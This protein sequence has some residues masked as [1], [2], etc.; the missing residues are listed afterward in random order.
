MSKI[1]SN[2]HKKLPRVAVFDSGLGGVSVLKHLVDMY[3]GVPF[4][5]FADNAHF[6]YGVKNKKTIISYT[7]NI[8]S[9]LKKKGVKIVIF[10][11]NTVSASALQAM[12]KA[13][14]DMIFIG[15]LIPSAEEVVDLVPGNGKVA[16]IATEA[17]INSKW[18]QTHIKKLNRSCK[19]DP[20]SCGLM[21]SLV[22]EGC[23]SGEIAELI[24]KKYLNFV[25]DDKHDA[26]LLACT[27]FSFLTPII[28]RIVPAK[29]KVV[30]PSFVVARYVKKHY[31]DN[32]EYVSLKN[33]KIDLYVTDNLERFRKHILHVFPK[34]RFNIK[35]VNI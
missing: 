28:K 20:K 16:V 3:P 33:A 6:P 8:C 25:C 24:V 23:F 17:T 27:H 34:V 21:V 15:I 2:K 9:F 30:D 29:T 31:L 22:E 13:E 10:A 19:V 32:Y 1:I 35:L 4:I 7:K 5:Y 12:R 18:Y 26:L 14:K 11:C